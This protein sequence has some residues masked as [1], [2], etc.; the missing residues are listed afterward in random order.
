VLANQL[1][2][3]IILCCKQR[4]IEIRGHLLENTLVCS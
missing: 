2:L 4:L 1:R 3:Q